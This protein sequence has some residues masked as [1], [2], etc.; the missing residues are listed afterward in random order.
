ML[1]NILAIGLFVFLLDLNNYDYLAGVEGISA[2]VLTIFILLNRKKDFRYFKAFRFTKTML[3]LTIIGLW[4]SSL[5][6]ENSINQ[7]SFSFETLIIFAF[8]SVVGV[9]AYFIIKSEMKLYDE[10]NSFNPSAT[11]YSSSRETRMSPA[12]IYEPKSSGLKKRPELES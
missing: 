4:A 3:P 10:I 5:I 11:S 1:L 8:G 2:F 6:L 7:G 12:Y 9:V